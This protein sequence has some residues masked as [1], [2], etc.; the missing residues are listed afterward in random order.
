MGE[1]NAL[2]PA[3]SEFTYYYTH[4]FHIS[5]LSRGSLKY[6]WNLCTEHKLT[7]RVLATVSDIHLENP[8]F[9]CPMR[10]KEGKHLHPL[11]NAVQRALPDTLREH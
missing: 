6:L 8:Y 3:S 9:F 1:A 5:N 11:K 7:K 2:V 10:T 4:M